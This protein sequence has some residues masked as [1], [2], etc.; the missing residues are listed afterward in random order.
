MSLVSL[1]APLL[2][3]LII[4]FSN[5]SFPSNLEILPKA[6]FS[7]SVGTVNLTNGCSEFNLESKLLKY[8]SISI[9]FDC[10]K[11]TLNDEFSWQISLASEL[12]PNIKL[13]ISRYYSHQSETNKSSEI[14]KIYTL[15][16][17]ALAKNHFSKILSNKNLNWFVSVGEVINSK[18][19]DSN[20]EFQAKL[21]IYH[22][23][24]KRIY[25]SYLPSIKFS[26][27]SSGQKLDENIRLVL[28][29]ANKTKKRSLKIYNEFD[30]PCSDVA[31]KNS[32]NI[33]GVGFLISYF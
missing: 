32:K 9:H 3:P 24:S 33:L 27:T 21:E 5:L 16:S 30:W 11:K 22:W 14:N 28:G 8:K 17:I 7:F 6:N 2:T 10:N 15:E 29:I 1:L 19:Y 31:D 18:N 13:L 23:L 20:Y 4:N 12:T 25:F 26:L